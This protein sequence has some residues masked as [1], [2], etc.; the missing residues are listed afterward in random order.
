MQVFLRTLNL[1]DAIGTFCIAS[2]NRR[3]SQ[4]WLSADF[5]ANDLSFASWYPSQCIIHWSQCHHMKW[6]IIIKKCLKTPLHC[7]TSYRYL[8]WLNTPMQ[9]TDMRFNPRFSA[10]S[11]ILATLGYWCMPYTCLY[12]Q[13]LSRLTAS[14]QCDLWSNKILWLN[15]LKRKNLNACLSLEFPDTNSIIFLVPL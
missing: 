13:I 7:T 15:P 8:K 1:K 2:S 10:Q 4:H 6:T 12:E 9:S 14:T 11:A 3:V 5:L